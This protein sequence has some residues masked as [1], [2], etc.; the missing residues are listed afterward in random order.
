MDERGVVYPGADDNASGA[1]VMLALARAASTREFEHTI[2]FAAFGAEEPG[3]VGSGVYI[4]EPLWPLEQ[5]LGVINFDMVGRRFFEIGSG[6]RATAAVVGLEADRG[7]RRAAERAA[8]AA[9]L[10]LVESPARLL[11]LFG[12]D[13]RTDDWWFRRHGVLAVHFSTSMHDDYHRPT[14][15]AEKL[16]PAQMVRVA[17][18]AYGVLAYLADLPVAEEAGEAS[19][20]GPERHDSE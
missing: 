18:T 4:R 9:G 15:T 1:A 14:D 10:E 8:Q 3:L 19:S 7:A 20:G 2:V 11:E 12:F 6:K 5:T 16:V 17:R 13:D